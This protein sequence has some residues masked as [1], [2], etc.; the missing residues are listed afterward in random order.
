MSG[1]DGTEIRQR[2]SG[3]SVGNRRI[4]VVGVGG[5]GMSAV[6]SVLHAMGHRVT[7]SDLK[8]SPA[9]DRLAASGVEVA[10]GHDGVLMDDAEILSVSTAVP[11]DNPEV[12]LATG[13]GTARGAQGRDAVCDMCLSP[14]HSGLRHPRKDDDH[15]ASRSDA[16]RGRLEPS[17]LIG[18]DVNEIGTNAV[19]DKGEWLVVEAD[20]SD[21]TFLALDPEV[22]VLTNVEPDHLDH[23]G[24]FDQLVA[25][26]EEFCEKATARCR[27]E[28]RRSVAAG[29]GR[30]APGC[31]RRHIG[32]GRRSDR[33][34]CIRT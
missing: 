15:H 5:A 16:R 7:G 25:A 30:T 27:H 13:A 20:E 32:R 21:G 14:G 9:L 17:F 12:M 1:S 23:Y 26:F 19:W 28:R 18:G 31:A 29:I 34:T 3:R 6:A 11:D 4:H 10:V 22:A 24:G 8:A 2:G 33:R